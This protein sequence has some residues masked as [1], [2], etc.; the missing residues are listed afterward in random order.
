MPVGPM[1]EQ[2]RT[3]EITILMQKKEFSV[4]DNSLDIITKTIILLM[5]N[6][7]KAKKPFIIGKLFNP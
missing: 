3:L 7:A 6:G 2:L 1:V 4:H 5:Q